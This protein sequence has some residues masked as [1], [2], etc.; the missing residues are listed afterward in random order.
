MVYTRDIPDGRPI[1][2]RGPVF[3]KRPQQGSKKP[4]PTPGIGPKPF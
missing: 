3:Y 4:R 1:P 2:L